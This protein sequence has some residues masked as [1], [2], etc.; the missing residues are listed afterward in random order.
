MN[1]S[2]F[3]ASGAY[4]CVVKP[5][6]NCDKKIG[7][8]KENTI[9]KIFGD[10][11]NYTYELVQHK[12]ISKIDKNNDFTI[13]IISNCEIDL[14]YIKSHVNDIN[15]CELIK[16]KNKIYQIIY[17][18][19]GEDLLVFLNNIK[20]TFDSYN[21]LKKFIKLFIG[22]KLLIK[23]N[24]THS[25]IKLE[26]ILFNG[27]KLILIDF[28]LLVN[29]ENIFNSHIDNLKYLTMIHYPDEIKLYLTKNI[30]NE[31][32][33]YN[34]NTNDLLE[35]LNN[36]ILKIKFLN[37]NSNYFNYFKSINDLYN[38]II[39]E[40][41]EYYKRFNKNNYKKNVK[42]IFGKKLDIYQL[43]I[44]LLEVIILIII[45]NNKKQILQ[46]PIQI[47]DIIKQ[48]LEPDVEKR[49]NIDIL[50]EKY[51]LLFT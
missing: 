34:L 36:Y 33:N 27:N 50:I 35:L 32:Y 21:F 51:S 49:I 22:I 46:I 13:K 48:M 11:E 29:F 12:K 43:G 4:G 25:D 3:I 28:G 31:N 6:Y 15:N 26:N 38:Y 16:D 2:K 24:L 7:L 18:D 17:E 37:H 1:H 44:V 45:S 5:A 47:F 19:G 41:N 8:L 10:K 9:A 42:K 23:N 14:S 20:S 30:I 39:K 40:S